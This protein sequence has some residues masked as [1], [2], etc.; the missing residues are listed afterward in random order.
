VVEKNRKP[1]L[2]ATIEALQESGEI[3]TEAVR[4]IA[5]LLNDHFRAFD[6]S[7]ALA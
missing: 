6:L 7:Q 1:A 3:I 4:W 5:T 2:L